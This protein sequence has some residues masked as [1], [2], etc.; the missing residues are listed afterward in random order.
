MKRYYLNSFNNLRMENFLLRNNDIQKD[1]QGIYTEDVEDYKDYQE[2]FDS[3]EYFKSIQ[4]FVNVFELEYML[5]KDNSTYY[6]RVIEDD[7]ANIFTLTY[8]SQDG[9]KD[10]NISDVVEIRRGDILC[11]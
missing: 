11:D 10:V 8:E 4:S 6:A 2:Q 9:T 7:T 3:L 5:S 1:N